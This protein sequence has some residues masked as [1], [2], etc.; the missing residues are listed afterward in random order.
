MGSYDIIEHGPDVT[1]MVADCALNSPIDMRVAYSLLPVHRPGKIEISKGDKIPHCKIPGSIVTLDFEGDSRGLVRRKESFFKNSVSMDISCVE[2]NANVKLSPQNIHLCGVTSLSIINEVVDYLIGYIK[3]IQEI[4]TFAAENPDLRDKTIEWLKDASMGITTKRY[5]TIYKGNLRI[6]TSSRHTLV[7]AISAKD[8]SESPDEKLA[9]LYLRMI[10]EIVYH[11]DFC[12]LLDW[13]RN[14]SWVC[15]HDLAK[16]EPVIHMR[17]TNS[18]LNFNIG[19]CFIFARIF[20]E[21]FPEYNISYDNTMKPSTITINIPYI[22]TAEKLATSKKKIDDFAHTFMLQGSGSFTHSGPWGPESETG[23]NKFISAMK[24][25][26][27][28]IPRD[29]D[30]IMELAKPYL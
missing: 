14:I 5:N 7:R 9:K 8:I 19:I 30:A 25:M 29:N 23:Y 27:K 16:M 20:Q 11:E 28:L 18:K 3:E 13:C 24:I 6:V 17:N 12:R 2:K 10:P 15:D 26:E 21:N 4:L 1:M 22:P